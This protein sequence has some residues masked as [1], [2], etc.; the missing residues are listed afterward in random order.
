MASIAENLKNLRT[1]KGLTQEDVALQIGLTRQAISS[2]E[3]G[4]TQP[5]LDLLTRFAEIYGVEIEDVLYGCGRDIR[6]ERAIS[7]LAW[8]TAGVWLGGFLLCGVLSVTCHT[9]I[10]PREM[11]DTYFSVLMWV[12]RLQAAS[13]SLL[14]V[15]CIGLLIL[16]LGG[17]YGGSMRR[18][19]MC[20]TYMLLGTLA[21]MFL[22]AAADPVYVLADILHY[23]FGGIV[24]MS[25]TMGI[26]ITTCRVR[27]RHR[28]LN[29]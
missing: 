2:Y 6:G 5:P 22:W 21:A 19:A 12:E 1:A 4:R 28:Q 17:G 13:L 26:N 15:G 10:S 23:A 9:M 18:K 7:I 14:L 27:K 24:M 20:W 8:V 16:D 29:K 25:V 3:S 11:P